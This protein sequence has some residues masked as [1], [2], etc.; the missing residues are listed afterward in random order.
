VKTKTTPGSL[1]V[2]HEARVA[3]HENL[4]SYVNKNCQLNQNF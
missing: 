1:H 2:L 4:R 3:L